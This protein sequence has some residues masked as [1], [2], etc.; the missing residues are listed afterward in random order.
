MSL[1]GRIQE[2][3]IDAAA[4][5]TSNQNN[6][7]KTQTDSQKPTMA[8]VVSLSI[9]GTTCSVKLT[10]GSILSN[11]IVGVRVVSVGDP[12]AICGSKIV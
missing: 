3:A 8:T 12:V 10:N 7:R 2:I 4:N 11:I 9:D 6:F 5:K 1:K